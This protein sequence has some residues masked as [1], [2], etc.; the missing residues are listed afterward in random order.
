[1][2]N[3][4]KKKRKFSKIVVVVLLASVAM[5]TVA[6]TIIFCVKG[7]VPDSLITAF[8]GFAAGEAGFLGLIKHGEAKYTKDSKE[9]KA[10]G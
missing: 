9:T 6:Q 4:N 2:R 7:S 10:E 1:M 5:F 8:F 3:R